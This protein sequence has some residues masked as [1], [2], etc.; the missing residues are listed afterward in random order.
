M[1]EEKSEN[2]K[3]DDMNINVGRFC[4]WLTGQAHVP[5]V[6]ADREN[7]KIVMEFDHDCHVRY[8]THSICYPVVNSCSCSCS[9][10]FPVTHLTTFAEFRRI[11]SQAI[12]HGYEFGRCQKEFSFFG[13]H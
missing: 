7:F 2:V 4:Q 9:V 6:H 13:M 11:I 5:L 3:A 8:G 1:T 10:T 12:V